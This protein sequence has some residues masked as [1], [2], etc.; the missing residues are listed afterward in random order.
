[1]EPY[2]CKLSELIPNKNEAAPIRKGGWVA[3]LKQ[4]HKLTW[5]D[6]VAQYRSISSGMTVDIF[7][8]KSL[9]RN[10]VSLLRDSNINDRI[11]AATQH[12]EYDYCIFGDS[13]YKVDTNL[14][15]YYREGTPEAHRWNVTMKHV[16]ISIE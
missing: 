4:Y 9:R 8:P 13:A 1:M 6:L 10:D 11:R 7:G 16:R 15:S 2:Q 3:G 14:R 5:Y 12:E